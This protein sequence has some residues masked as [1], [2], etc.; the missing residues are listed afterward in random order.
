[1]K[2]A[3]SGAGFLIVSSYSALPQ[4]KSPNPQPKKQLL[5]LGKKETKSLRKLSS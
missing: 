2:A 4:E 5:S 1:M 3:P